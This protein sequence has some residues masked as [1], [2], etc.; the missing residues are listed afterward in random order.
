LRINGKADICEV[1][2]MTDRTNIIEM[3]FDEEM[4][5]A[6]AQRERMAAALKAIFDL[7]DDERLTVI[8]ADEAEKTPP[9]FVTD[10]AFDGPTRIVLTI[11]GDNE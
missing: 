7:I 1:T 8:I 2:N 5:K 4:K 9:R 3:S 10:A 6:T 11:G